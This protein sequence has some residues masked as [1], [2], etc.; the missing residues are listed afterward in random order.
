MIALAME[1]RNLWSDLIGKEGTT[2][3]RVRLRIEV[4]LEYKEM[5]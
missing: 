2:K 1:L 3:T 5:R 4:R